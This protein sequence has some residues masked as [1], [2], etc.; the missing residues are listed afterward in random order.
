MLNDPAIGRRLAVRLVGLQVAAAALGGLVFL[1]GGGRSAL[2]ALAGGL[3]VALGN[4]LMASRGLRGLRAGEV[5]VR[6]LAGL[7]LKWVTVTGGLY[8][9]LVRWHLPPAPAIAGLALALAAHLLMFRQTQ[10]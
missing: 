2:A 7:V 5:L 10:P 6:F 4:A 9:V 8:L 1:I 3:C